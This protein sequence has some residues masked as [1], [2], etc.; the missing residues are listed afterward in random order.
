MQP[1]RGERGSR[2]RSRG[3][4]A[5]GPPA[6]RWRPLSPRR[7]VS[8][9]ATSGAPHTSPPPITKA[10][11]NDHQGDPASGGPKGCWLDQLRLATRAL[12]QLTLA[13]LSRL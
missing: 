6:S 5:H 7:P 8:G 3:P 2:C 9:T 1:R 13:T 10:F 12:D 4:R 11:P